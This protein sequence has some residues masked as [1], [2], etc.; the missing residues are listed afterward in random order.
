MKNIILSVEE[1]VLQAVRRYANARNSS[2]DRL[3]QDYLRQI[4]ERENRA[5]KARQKLREL[6]D[7]STA[8]VGERTW[9][10]DDLHAC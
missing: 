7:A 1:E 2:V 9:R 4:A 6:S 10:R 5:A 3:V 8:R